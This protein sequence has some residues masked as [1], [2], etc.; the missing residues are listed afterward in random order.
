MI[1]YVG[2][3]IGKTAGMRLAGKA[4]VIGGIILILIGIRIFVDGV[5]L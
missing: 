3:I 1:C 5:F 4:E 2:I